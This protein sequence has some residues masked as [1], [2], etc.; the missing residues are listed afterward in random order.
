M[1]VLTADDVSGRMVVRKERVM[2][3]VDLPIF[4]ESNSALAALVAV[5]VVA[6]F[7]LGRKAFQLI[8]LAATA[9]ARKVP[10]TRQALQNWAEAKSLVIEQAKCRHFLRGPFTFFGSNAPVY[11]IKVRNRRGRVREGFAQVRGLL[12]RVEGVKVVWDRDPASDVDVPDV[13]DVN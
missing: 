3:G 13:D 12:G 9:A 8:D 2:L 11:R 10:T 7:V 4:G 5:A 1:E 6:A